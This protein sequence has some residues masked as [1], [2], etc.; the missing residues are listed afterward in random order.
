MILLLSA[1]ITF[2]LCFFLV[3]VLFAI[4]RFF[5][6][7]AIVEERT[8][9]VYVLFGKV[10]AI[11]VGLVVALGIRPVSV[12]EILA[13]F[14]LAQKPRPFPPVSFLDSNDAPHKIEDFKGTYEEFQSTKAQSATAPQRR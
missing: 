2:V 1:V 6:V 14:V 7:Y 4:L 11:T 12:R 8:C 3:P 10:V 13:A 9:Q 5:G